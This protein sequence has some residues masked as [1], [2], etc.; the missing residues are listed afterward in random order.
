[1]PP[2]NES[3]DSQFMMQNPY[4]PMS[5]YGT[6]FPPIPPMY[7]G[8]GQEMFPYAGYMVPH[9]MA[10][11]MAPTSNDSEFDV[12]PHMQ[13]IPGHPSVYDAPPNL[14]VPSSSNAFEANKDSQLQAQSS[15]EVFENT[16]I[17]GADTQVQQNTSVKPLKKEDPVLFKSNA[18]ISVP[19]PHMQEVTTEERMTASSDRASSSQPK[20]QPVAQEHKQPTSLGAATAVRDAGVPSSEF[21]FEKANARFQKHMGPG[22]EQGTHAERMSSV[23]SSS[24]SSFYDK[25][26]G[27]F[28]NISSEVK[29]RH[30]GGDRN[31][32]GVQIEEKERNILTFGDQAIN[33]RGSGFRGRGR[34]RGG[35]GRGRSEKRPAWA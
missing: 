12:P 19:H 26:T 17:S 18:P 13:D 32:R 1:M 16:S 11:A 30:E 23:P 35:R 2:F 8:F 34:G 25:K 3:H 28:D 14:S 7:T 5:S 29:D 31:G 4:P 27:F 15:A 10:H 21:D 6:M 20:S 9:Y 24:S 33:F 22:L